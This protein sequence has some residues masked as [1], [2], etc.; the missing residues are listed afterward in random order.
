MSGAFRFAILFGGLVILSPVEVDAQSTVD[1]SASCESSTFNE[2]VNII[3]EELKDVK[4][5]CA[6]NQQH[7]S[8]MDASSLC[9]YRT[10]Q[11]LFFCT[12]TQ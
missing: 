11:S 12:L 5:V 6:S 9:E 3:R 8:E 10:Y 1:D 2:A 7:C 4:H